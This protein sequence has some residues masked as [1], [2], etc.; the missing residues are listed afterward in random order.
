MSAKR[1]KFRVGQVVRSYADHYGRIVSKEF[2]KWESFDEW[3]Y[4]DQDGNWHD[5]SEL[6]PLTRREKGDAR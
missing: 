3:S 2:G 4:E 1:A 6:R 5:E